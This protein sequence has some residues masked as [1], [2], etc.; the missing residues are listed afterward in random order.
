MLI[1]FLTDANQS[2]QLGK[3]SPLLFFDVI[4]RDTVGPRYFDP[5]HLA[6]LLLRDDGLAPVFSRQ[7]VPI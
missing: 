3:T 6:V 1:P 2:N 4:C 7:N 5:R